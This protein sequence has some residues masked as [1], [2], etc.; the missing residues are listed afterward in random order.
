MTRPSSVDAVKNERTEKLF[1]VL[2]WDAGDN[3]LKVINPKGDVLDVVKLI[4]KMDERLK[5]PA[6][7]FERTFSSAQLAKL[8]R[9]EQEQFAME[10]KKRLER[11]A[12]ASQTS[13]ASSGTP[14]ARRASSRTEGLIDRKASTSGRRPAAQWSSNELT[15]YRHHIDKLRDNDIF[16]IAIEGHGTFQITKS[17]FQRVFNNVIMDPEYRTQGVYRYRDFPPE[18]QPFTKA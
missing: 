10:E 15:F 4:F 2:D 16:A 3:K 6:A 11:A 9:W 5:I 13:S 18:A 7:D 1:I 14:R 8:D 17:E 12:R